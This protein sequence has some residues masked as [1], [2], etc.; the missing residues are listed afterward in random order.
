[1]CVFNLFENPATDRPMRQPDI[2]QACVQLLGPDLFSTLWPWITDPGSKARLRAVNKAMLGQV[3][4]EWV[5]A[6][7]GAWA[8]GPHAPGA[9][10]SDAPMLPGT[11][12]R[13]HARASS[14]RPACARA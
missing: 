12:T 7:Y 3:D 6:G 8:H 1:M 13:T 11:H 14:N 9:G 4:G 2:M 5:G 10:S